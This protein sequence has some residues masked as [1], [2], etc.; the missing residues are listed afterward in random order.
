MQ[1]PSHPNVH[2]NSRHIHTYI[3]AYIHTYIQYNVGTLSPK[4]ASRLPPHT[5]THTYM[6]TYIHT[7]N[8]IQVPSQ[9]NAH[10]NSRQRRAMP[11]HSMLRPGHIP[12]GC[13]QIQQ[14][15]VPIVQQGHPPRRAAH[16]RADAQCAVKGVHVC[17]FV[18]VCLR[19]CRNVTIRI[20]C[21]L[22]ICTYIQILYIPQTHTH[23]HTYISGFI[24][25][26]NFQERRHVYSHVHTCIYAHTHKNPQ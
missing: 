4:C 17:V 13:L 12:W 11:S 15:R 3:H 2:P 18:C 25:C 26:W 10:S 1:V 9:P 6:H 8:T 20:E 5:H 24:L 23:I 21:T 7:F 16:W 14:I 19:P 22:L